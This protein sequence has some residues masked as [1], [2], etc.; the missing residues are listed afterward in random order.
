MICRGAG[1]VVVAA[2]V[3]ATTVA[4]VVARLTAASQHGRC[5]QLDND[6]NTCVV[7]QAV[8]LAAV[9][10]CADEL[11]KPEGE[12]TSESVSEHPKSS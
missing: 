10:N 2:A 7:Q 4:D 5:D 11:E 3:A 9:V 6:L 8:A 12:P 1:F